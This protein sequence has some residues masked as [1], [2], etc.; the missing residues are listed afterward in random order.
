MV[1]YIQ[2]G[3]PSDVREKREKRIKEA[4]NFKSGTREKPEIHII[5]VINNTNAVYFSKPGKEASRKSS[6]NPNDMA[7]NVGK[8]FE[9]HA[10]KDIWKDLLNL[11]VQIS[12]DSY[13]QLNV[14][15]YRIAYLMDCKE[16]DG[17]IRYIPEG[18]VKETIERIQEEINSKGYNFKLLEF[19][20]F[21][22]ILSW[23]EDVKYQPDCRF[24]NYK[25]GRINTV[26]SIISVP[27]IFR[28][29]VDLVMKSENNLLK[30]DFSLIVDVVDKF[31]KSRGV[32]SVSNKELVKYLSP[33][34]E[35]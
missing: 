6:N 25:T 33:Y 2:K 30:V 29:F 16:V 21:V 35:Q 15:L 9:K 20:H 19:L 24:E 32:H 14:L 5:D 10:F 31:S 8:L 34:L 22:D 12:E 26:L 11:S 23:N 4:I 28:E 18:E 13:K 7:P 27:F 3:H 1:T 17:K